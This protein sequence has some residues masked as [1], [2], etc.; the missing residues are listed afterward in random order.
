GEGRTL[1][2][3][4]K[5]R[6]HRLCRQSQRQHKW[7]AWWCERVDSELQRGQILIRWQ[8]PTIARKKFSQFPPHLPPMGSTVLRL[9]RACGASLEIRTTEGKGPHSLPNPT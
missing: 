7:A 3:E 2:G 9:P 6:W 1:G 5:S 8:L 4:L